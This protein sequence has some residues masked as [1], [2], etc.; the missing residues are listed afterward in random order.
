MPCY[1]PLKGYKDRE[2]GGLTFRRER[3]SEK[4]EV[5]CSQCLGCR[6]DYSRMWALRITHE[7]SMHESTGGN[8][9]ITLTYREKWECD[10]Q[11]LVNKYHVPD[12]WSLDHSHIQ[13]FLKRLRH[14]FPQKIKYFVVGEY[15]NVCE[16]GID[17]ELV[18]CPLCNVGRPHYHAILFNCSFSDLVSYGS[19][20]GELRYTSPLLESTWK[21]GFVDVDEANFDSAAYCSRYALKKVTGAMADDHYMRISEDGVCSWIKPEYARM[22]RNPGI[23]K[24][25]FEVFHGD[26]FPSDTCPRPGDSPVYGMPRYYEEIFKCMDPL[27]MEDIKEK[28]KIWMREHKDEFTPERLM[29][30]YKVKKRQAEMLKRK[31]Q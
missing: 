30:K 12:D 27:T 15:G 16:H 19:D 18:G 17:L 14:K 7:C 31:L 11:Q 1:S 8:C 20:H 9:F 13:K 29:D 25:W 4:M 10:E 28:R 3:G 26:C 2:T 24:D 22:S 6:L 23:G 5:A 21:Y